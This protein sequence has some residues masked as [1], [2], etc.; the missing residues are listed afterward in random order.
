MAKFADRPACSL[1]GGMYKKLGLMCVLLNTPKLLFLDEPTIGVDPLSRRELWDMMY[2]M[3]GDKM[4]IILSTSYMDEAERCAK[5]H[6]LDGGNVMASGEP[7]NVL[8]S[9]GVKTFEEI[10][11]KREIK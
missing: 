4:T 6:I 9:F 8:Q 10:F 5:A 7:E 1:S 11:L 2:A 3:S